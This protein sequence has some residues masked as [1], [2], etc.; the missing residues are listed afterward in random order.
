MNMENIVECICRR[1]RVQTAGGMIVEVESDK[2]LSTQLN[3]KLL[4]E[5]SEI[6]QFFK[7]H[8]ILATRQLVRT[9]PNQQKTAEISP[10]IKSTDGSLSP[11]QR[12]N[13]LLKMKGDFTRSDY[14][15]H[16][17]DSFHY[18]VNKWTSHNDMQDALHLNKIQIV[19]ERR[20]HIGRKYRVVDTEEIEESLYVKLL[21]DRKMHISTLS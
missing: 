18:K 14:M 2:P 7:H 21:Q 19:E 9:T 20:G 15:R 11:R 1:Y 17:F 13:E 8:K 4:T 10:K 6:D 5:D 3:A 12:L 16:M